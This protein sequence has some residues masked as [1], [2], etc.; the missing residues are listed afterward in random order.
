MY[1]PLNKSK[2]LKKNKTIAL[3]FSP[4]QDKKTKKEKREKKRFMFL[5]LSY[6]QI[7]ISLLGDIAYE[8]R[9]PSIFPGLYQL[10]VGLSKYCF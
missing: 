6:I 3:P 9:S 1:G 2:K 8:M 4:K 10:E 5:V 7:Y